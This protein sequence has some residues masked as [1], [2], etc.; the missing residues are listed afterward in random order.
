MQERLMLHAHCM[1]GGLC[2][3]CVPRRMM[4]EARN[5]ARRE[6]IGGGA[7]MGSCP[8]CGQHNVKTGNN[9]HMRCWACNVSAPLPGSPPC[10]VQHPSGVRMGFSACRS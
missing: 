6:V 2:A 4:H 5:N 3:G 7:R 10:D 9:N 8:G 1:V